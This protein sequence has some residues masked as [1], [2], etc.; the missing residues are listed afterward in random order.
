MFMC[1][2]TLEKRRCLENVNRFLW[3]LFQHFFIEVLIAAQSWMS[4]TCFY[5]KHIK[6]LF[7][8]TFNV[9]LL[10]LRRLAHNTKLS[11]EIFL[12]SKDSST[13]SVTRMKFFSVRNQCTS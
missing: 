3:K 8:H 1:R 6:S 13:K 4:C 9:I 12:F 11:L 10:L 7:N 2:A 5:D